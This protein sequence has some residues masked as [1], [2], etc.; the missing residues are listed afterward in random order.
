[1]AG[2]E[3]R[4]LRDRRSTAILGALICLATVVRVVGLGHQSFWF[5]EADT[6]AILHTSLGH[7]LARVPRWETTPPLYFVLAWGWSHLSGYGESGLRS[8]SALAGILTVPVG[9][10][11]GTKLR[12]RRVGLI[13]AALIACNPLLVWY[14]QEARAY[15][16][17]VLLTSL[18][19]LAFL[20]TLERPTGRTVVA[21]AAISA[22]AIA[23]HYYAALA[24]VP[25]AVWLLARHRR[26]PQIRLAVVAVALWYIPFAL[27]A[28][29]QLD[30]LGLS[31]WINRIPLLQRTG[32]LPRE[33]VLGPTAPA[34]L[35]LGLVSALAVAVSAFFLIRRA[36][37]EDRQAIRVAGVLALAGFG[38]VFA[39]IVLGFDQMNTRNLLALWL[40]VALVVALGFGVS[41][42]GRLGLAGAGALCLVGLV[43]IVAVAASPSLERPAWR[44]VAHVID[45]GVSRPG[46]NRVIL[47]VNGCQKRPLS[48]YVP[49]LQYLPGSGATADEIDLITVSGQR[50]W[51]Q[52]WFSGWFVVCKPQPGLVTVPTR[53]GQFRATGSPTRINQFSVLRLRS[54]SPVH[55]SQQT[56][57][58][59][60]LSGALTLA[61]ER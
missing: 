22:L 34:Q 27:M 50:N 52:V 8:L 54:A 55:V 46:T 5:D 13:V 31:N 26:L 24:I 59:V 49:G 47:L 11:I 38:I 23:T 16:L 30:N 4:R 2:P 15:S 29:R 60:G 56:F 21:W 25:E 20:H 17:L 37:Q 45:S 7:L 51:Y 33:F 19:V 6:V 9:F 44:S 12:S 61:P 48:L 42:A 40:P 43:V 35:W 10:A 58:N 3:T 39:L 14:S 53:I 57:S 18:T 36:D 41:G 32:D 28:L 1:M